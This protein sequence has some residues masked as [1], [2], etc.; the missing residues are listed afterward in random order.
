MSQAERLPAP[1]LAVSMHAWEPY[2]DKAA[3]TAP[4]VMMLR[5]LDA[6]A[7]IAAQAP[8]TLSRV[9]LDVGWSTSQPE[10][11]KPSLDWWY[12]WRL[13]TLFEAL[14]VR[15]LK[16]YTVV[17]QS[18]PWSRTT[19]TGTPGATPGTTDSRRYPDHPDAIAEWAYWFAHTFSDH[20]CEIEVWNEPNLTTFTG[21]DP[22]TGASA[23]TPEKY[24]ALLKVFARAARDG[25]RNVKIIAPSLSTP[26][27]TFLRACYSLGM[28]PYVDIIGIHAYQ[29]RQSVMAHSTD[30]AGLTADSGEGWERWRLA[31]GLPMIWSVMRDYGDSHK[32]IWNTEAGWSASP[33]GVGD[34]APYPDRDTKAAAYFRNWLEMLTAGTDDQTAQAAYSAVTLSTAY[35]LFDPLSVDAHQKGFE[36]IRQ[37]GTLKP[38]AAALG[39]WRRSRPHLRPLYGAS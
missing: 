17:H 32:P 30:T 19:G 35:Q 13:M 18:P 25:N 20:I 28:K 39:A 23:A 6:L 24:V 4:N 1:H 7:E 15:G 3:P 26:D 38:Q 14:A 21:T 37:D 29:G 2:Y 31:K 12:N 8:A 11:K 33:T 10:D 34:P 22:S 16:A 36:I 9:R 27:W 5:H